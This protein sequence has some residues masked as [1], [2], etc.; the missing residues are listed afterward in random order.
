[1]GAYHL[2]R[3][4]GAVRILKH[5]CGLDPRHEGVTLAA[6]IRAREG[7]DGLGGGRAG[8]P[9]AVQDRPELQRLGVPA[10]KTRREGRLRLLFQ[11][12]NRRLTVLITYSLRIPFHNIH[13]FS[14][15]LLICI[16]APFHGME[17]VNVLIQLYVLFLLARSTVSAL[18]SPPAGPRTSPP[19]PMHV[20]L[21]R[22]GYDIGTPTAG[23]RGDGW[24][25]HCRLCWAHI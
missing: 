5:A 13:P 16:S 11:L 14:P 19:P 6:C 2:T 4:G 12:C 17:D 15:F 23:F 20:P 8:D 21:G 24:C 25:H 1:M 7:R 9:F 3:N 10:A 22:R 18:L